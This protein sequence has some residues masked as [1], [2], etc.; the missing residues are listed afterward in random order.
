M[1]GFLKS[2]PLVIIF[3]IS[4]ILQAYEKPICVWFWLQNDILLFTQITSKYVWAMEWPE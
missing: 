1:T 3:I 4:K 2:K